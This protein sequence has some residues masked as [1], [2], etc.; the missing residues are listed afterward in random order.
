MLLI[1]RENNAV[2]DAISEKQMLQSYAL[3]SLF[4]IGVQQTVWLGEFGIDTLFAPRPHATA[5][6]MGGGQPIQPPGIAVATLRQGRNLA[7]QTADGR[8]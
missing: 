4:Q 8:L 5:S 3:Q 2:G 6:L 1:E 7:W